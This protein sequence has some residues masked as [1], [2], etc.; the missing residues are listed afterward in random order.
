M[1]EFIFD[2]VVTYSCNFTKTKFFQRFFQ[3]L[4]QKCW[5]LLLLLDKNSTYY[6]SSIKQI[7][8]R[9]F[10]ILINGGGL[11][12]NDLHE[13]STRTTLIE[14]TLTVRGTPCISFPC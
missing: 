6:E 12:E 14:Q 1:K 7:P 5:W 2:K 13:T 10:S 8:P 9:Q 11:R 4:C 3:G